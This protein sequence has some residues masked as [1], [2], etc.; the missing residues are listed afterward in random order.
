MADHP[1]WKYCQAAARVREM[2]NPPVAFRIPRP[3]RL[4]VRQEREELFNCRIFPEHRSQARNQ[5]VARN[6]GQD[7]RTGPKRPESDH[8]LRIQLAFSWHGH[9]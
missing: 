9:T 2:G 4:F 5:I 8:E 6:I 1:P 3:E 7:R